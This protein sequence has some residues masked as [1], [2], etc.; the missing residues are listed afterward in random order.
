MTIRIE[1]TG[2]DPAQIAQNIVSMAFLFAPN[3]RGVAQPAMAPVVEAETVET[4]QPKPRGRA[5]KTDVVIDHSAEEVKQ[6]AQQS[7]VAAKLAGEAD[8]PDAGGSSDSTQ[9]DAAGEPSGPAAD[10]APAEVDAVAEKPC[11]TIDELRAFTVNEYLNTCF[12]TLPE[13]KTAFQELLK[14]H[15]VIAIG[16]LPAD[17]INAFKA[18]VDAKIKAKLTGK[19]A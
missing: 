15:G 2:E 12:E 5:K 19:A 4:A 10:E 7:G 3:L 9:A 1:I 13:R 8:G 16:E 6:D 18:V 17:K 14:P 11:M